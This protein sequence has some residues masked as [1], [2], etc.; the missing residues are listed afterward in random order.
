VQGTIARHFLLPGFPD[1]LAR[2]PHIQISMS[3]GDR[4]VDMVQEGVD[5]VLRYG[6]LPDS[7]LVAR[8]VAT[9]DRLTCATPAYLARFGTPTSLASLDGHQMVGIRSVTTGNVT[10][11]EFDVHGEIQ[12]VSIPAV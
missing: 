2:H 4:W 10:P 8:Q 3:E 9:L 12:A 11:L 7:E 1:F 5:C 6:K